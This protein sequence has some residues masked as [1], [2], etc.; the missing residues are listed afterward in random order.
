MKHQG[1]VAYISSNK[2]QNK[3][4]W[5]FALDGE[6]KIYYGCGENMPVRATGNKVEVGDKIRFSFETN[7]R[8]R[9]NV[10]FNTIQVKEG[11]GTPAPAKKAY[12]GKAA[13]RDDYWAAKEVYDKSVTSPM[14]HYQNA[15]DKAVNLVVAA[16]GKDL[17][18]LP[19][20]KADK[21][22]G[23]LEMVKKVRDEIYGEYATAYETL[24]GGDPILAESVDE[25][26]AGKDDL[27]D[28]NQ[29]DMFNESALDDDDDG[30]D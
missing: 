6:D 30:W 5:S 17:L 14:I 12:G 1:I 23:F 21:F 9:H 22:Q 10:D 13:G 11:K 20:K 18:T 15:T 16:L 4:L 19:T 8:G 29:Q 3:D 25:S 28:M 2:W 27:E 24:Q 7:D 26:V